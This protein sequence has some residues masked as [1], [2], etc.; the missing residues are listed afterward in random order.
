[1]KEY[2][3][4]QIVLEKIHN[5]LN[6]PLSK[7]MTFGVFKISLIFLSIS[8]IS[9]LWEIEISFNPWN[10]VIKESI[11]FGIL[12]WMG[13]VVGLIL[14]GLSIWMYI[15]LV[16]QPTQDRM[17]PE[18]KLSDNELLNPIELAHMSEI[19]KILDECN[20]IEIPYSNPEYPFEEKRFMVTNSSKIDRPQFS[21]YLKLYSKPLQP[22]ILALSDL[23]KKTE[24]I[25]LYGSDINHYIFQ[26]EDGVMLLF[27]WRGWAEFIQAIKN[28]REGYTK[29][30]MRSSGFPSK[31]TADDEWTAEEEASWQELLN[32]IRKTS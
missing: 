10:I 23:V 13:L 29:Y 25:G 22:Y 8:I 11:D 1:M 21:D 24:L 12:Q 9:G 28:R 6:G 3:L 2:E 4:K 27:T 15:K 18:Y 19:D 30:Y 16:H 26:F 7:K 31:G 20:I 17:E 32:S 5:V 14:L